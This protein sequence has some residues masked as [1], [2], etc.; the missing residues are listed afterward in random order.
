V[1]RFFS[2]LI[3][4]SLA[5]CASGPSGDATLRPGPQRLPT[6]LAQGDLII[7]TLPGATVTVE[8]LTDKGLD[9]YYARRSTLLNPLKIFPRKTRGLLAFILRIQNVGRERVSF[10]PGQAALVDQQD[11]RS[12]PLSY[13]ELYTLFSEQS[14]SALALRTLE[15]T[16]LTKFLVVPPKIEREG[17]LL[18]PPVDPSAKAVILEVGSFYIGSA[19]Q[20]LLFEF[21]V[22]RTP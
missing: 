2:L 19:E 13:D 14:E 4:V 1:A 15:E 5:A 8:P 17:L 9:A 6:L 7:A 21:E 16:I 20:L 22:R 3:V 18:F 12:T 10:D 11:R